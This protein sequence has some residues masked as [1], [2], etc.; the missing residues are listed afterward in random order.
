MADK[1]KTCSFFGHWNVKLTDEQYSELVDLIKEL[2]IN[3]EVDTFLFGSKSNF[4]SICH[5]IESDLKKRYSHICRVGYTCS[6]GTCILETEKEYWER[7]YVNLGYKNIEIKG[8]EKECDFKQK[9][10]SGRASY[11]ERNYAMINDS[12]YCIFYCDNSYLP[13]MRK[14]SKNISFYREANSGT[15][16]AYEYA[17]RKNKTIFNIFKN[18]L[19]WSQW[20]GFKKVVSWQNGIWV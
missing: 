20:V 7:L 4:D 10:T 5:T 15:K 16:L 9:Y 3:E 8:F 13:E 14:Y 17:K 1:H 12:D 19:A 6:S 18:P 11:V 2:I